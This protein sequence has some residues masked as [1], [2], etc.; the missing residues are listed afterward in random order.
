MKALTI[1]SIPYVLPSH[2]SMPRRTVVKY[3]GLMKVHRTSDAIEQTAVISGFRFRFIQ[4]RSVSLI[5]L[6]TSKKVSDQLSIDG[7]Q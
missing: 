7:L 6:P 1:E 3:A 2:P 5:S 4:A